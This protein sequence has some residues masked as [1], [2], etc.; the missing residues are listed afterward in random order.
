MA[1]K[2]KKRVAKELTR[3]QRSRL[4]RERRMEKIL[5]WSVTAV[6]VVIVG[7]LVYGFVIEKIIKEREPVAIVN[8]VP[9]TTAEFQGR[10]RFTRAQIQQELQRWLFEQQAIDPTDSDMQPYLEY[11]QGAVRD[12][13]AQLS[14]ENALTLGEQVLDQ[15][16][17]EE[18]VRQEAERRDI[19]V[20][21]EELDQEIE[22]FFG[23]DRNPATPTPAPTATP[24]LTPT[25]VLTP[26]P[27]LTPLPT[28]TP[29]T[30]AAFR[31]RYDT[32]L[33]QT[34]KPLGISEQ[35]YR[36]WVETSLLLEELQEQ[37]VAEV[38]EMVD[39]VE[40][41]LLTAESEEQANEFAARLDAG[42]DFQTLAD[43]LAEDESD[44]SYGREL[45]WYPKSLLEDRLGA[46]LADLAFSLEV[47]EHGSPVPDQDGTQYT[48]IGVVGH[49]TRELDE[50]FRQQLGSKA[51]QE[52]LEAQE[53]LVERKGY[54]DRVPMEP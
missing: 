28:A 51:F 36:S 50:F 21:P 44:V 41:W 38:P 45:D 49:E 5:L 46:E 23:Y 6:G 9:I 54:Q 18:L 47:G 14:P 22:L 39:Q 7:V 11:A 25:E 17:Q 34:L 33:G 20:A 35:E 12:L 1:K 8:D 37:M 27:T 10:V 32:Y 3:K 19:V 43:E 30:E 40:L 48:V 13:Q 26:T 2:P 42:E 52:W 16:I 24:P 29:M 53:V 4:E 15:L 31:E